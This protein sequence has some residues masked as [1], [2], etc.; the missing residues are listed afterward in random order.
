MESE[1]EEDEDAGFERVAVETDGERLKRMRDV[2]GAEDLDALRDD[3]D[4]DIVLLS[5]P[6]SALADLPGMKVTPREPKKARNKGD[7]DERSPTSDEDSLPHDHRGSSSSSTVRLS[8]A[9]LPSEARIDTLAYD[10]QRALSLPGK[11]K[12]QRGTRT[13]GA[14]QVDGRCRSG[15]AAQGY[16][17]D[18]LGDKRRS[19]EADKHEGAPSKKLRTG[20]ARPIPEVFQA[21]KEFPDSEVSLPSHD[22]LDKPSGPPPHLPS[23]AH[24]PSDCL[25]TPSNGSAFPSFSSSQSLSGGSMMRQELQQ[26]QREALGMDRPRRLG[27]Q[28]DASSSKAREEWAC[29]ICTL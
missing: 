13:P 14:D 19:E 16:R 22:D 4:D 27:G 24:G 26:R 17:L 20:A 23:S 15:Q 3:D 1:N 29:H 5:D 10:I 21:A 7:A 9:I 8:S 25:N 28:I 12:Q 2:M 18:V 11:S 6:S